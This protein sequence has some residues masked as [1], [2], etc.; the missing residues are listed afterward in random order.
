MNGPI[1]SIKMLGKD[2]TVKGKGGIILQNKEKLIAVDH[3]TLEIEKGTTLG[4]VG[5]SGCGKSTLGRM[6]CRLE[7][8]S[9]GEI[10]FQGQPIHALK[11]ESLRRIRH[12]FQPVFQDPL[13]SLNPRLNV[14]QTLAEP[15][16]LYG[17]KGDEN[18]VIILLETV[19]LGNE[20]MHRYAHQLSGG[21]RQRLGIARALA[22][23]PQLLVADEPVSSLDVS[24]QA[25]VLNLFLSLQQKLQLTMVF[26]SHDLRVIS[27]LADRVAVMYV[28]RIMEMASTRELFDNP[29]HPYTQALLNALPRLEPGRGRK[30]AILTGEIPSPVNP[31]PGCRFY[32]RCQYREEGCRYYENEIIKISP[33]HNIACKHWQKVR[34]HRKNN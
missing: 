9:R 15:L 25:Q 8:P 18:E 13:G 5:E 12:F 4:L 29:C 27:Q 16:Q 11:G 31:V 28:G 1:L 33:E 34:E 24:I 10:Y 3:I 21:Q 32:S 19:G 22:V 26:I 6:L 23:G 20:V 7:A 17:K 30:R 14:F 2:Y